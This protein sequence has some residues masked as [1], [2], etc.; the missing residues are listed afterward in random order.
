MTPEQ[1][2]F[3][4]WFRYYNNDKHIDGIFIPHSVYMSN[5]KNKYIT[6]KN[7]YKQLKHDNL[8]LKEQIENLINILDEHKTVNKCWEKTHEIKRRII[9]RLCQKEDK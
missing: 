8:K 4:N 9:A 6:L 3:P 2:Y 1:K 7:K 5:Y